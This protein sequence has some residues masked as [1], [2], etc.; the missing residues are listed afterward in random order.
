M[1]H[2]LKLLST[3]STTKIWH[4]SPRK[5]KE[6]A[7]IFLWSYLWSGVGA[8]ALKKEINKK[9]LLLVQ[10]SII[11]LLFLAQ[12]ILCFE[13]WSGFWKDGLQ[14]VDYRCDDGSKMLLNWGNILVSSRS[15]WFQKSKMSVINHQKTLGS[16]KDRRMNIFPTSGRT[17]RIWEEK[18]SNIRS[19]C[20]TRPNL[21]SPI[22]HIYPIQ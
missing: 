22:H 5:L 19:G 2:I 15:W 16:S 1:W 20:R 17:F 4:R 14:T 18:R 12:R 7:Q 9:N 8:R 10:G 11:S 13:S 3:I 6:L 21:N